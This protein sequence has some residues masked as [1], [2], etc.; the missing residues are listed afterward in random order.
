M[1]V[2]ILTESYLLLFIGQ[3]KWFLM[4]CHKYYHT[5]ILYMC[6]HWHIIT[7]VANLIGHFLINFYGKILWQKRYSHEYIMLSVLVP[8]TIVWIF[9]ALETLPEN[10]MI[11]N[12]TEHVMFSAIMLYMKPL[13]ELFQKQLWIEKWFTGLRNELL[14]WSPHESLISWKLPQVSGEWCLDNS[15]ATTPAKHI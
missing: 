12:L 2:L 6:I 11:F 15:V 10:N 13:V 5:Y 1:L 14:K 4:S 7:Y 3:W 9:V 8:R